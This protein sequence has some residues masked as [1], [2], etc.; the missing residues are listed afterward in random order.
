MRGLLPIV[1]E[2]DVEAEEGVIWLLTI[3]G[4]RKVENYQSR[5]FELLD[6]STKILPSISDAMK[7]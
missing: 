3:M 2:D 4:E 1:E 7:A 6:E 5:N